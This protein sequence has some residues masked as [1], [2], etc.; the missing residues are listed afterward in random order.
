MHV[1]T[2]PTPE[3]GDRSYIVDDGTWGVVVDP[4]RDIDRWQQVI[5]ERGL[6]I[7]MVCE[8]HRHNDY[9]TGGAAL[10]RELGA[11]YVVP[12]GEV[13]DRCDEGVS[14]GQRI[15]FGNLSL[16]VVETPGHTLGHVSYVVSHAGDV[17]SHAGDVVSHAGDVV[18]HARD[19]VSHARDVV[20]HAGDVVSHARDVVSDPQAASVAFTGGSLLYGN[21]GR[22]D[23]VDPERTRE[24]T[25]AQLRSVRR[26]A[27]GLDEETLLYP[28][29]GFGSFCAAGAPSTVEVS[30]VG[31]ERLANLAL[32]SISEPEFV[33]ELISGLSD[34]PSYY[35]HV[36]EINR[37]GP[38]AFAP[39]PVETL[40]PEQLAA[41][42]GAG[43]WVVDLRDSHSF[44]ASHLAGTVNFPLDR[45]LATWLGWLAPWGAP[46]TLLAP[47]VDVAMVA[48]RALSRIGVDPAGVVVTGEVAALAAAVGAEVQSYPVRTWDDVVHAGPPNRKSDG[49]HVA[50]GILDVRT[51]DERREGGVA[52]SLHIPLHQLP[53]RIDSLPAE[54]LW[55]HCQSGYRAA[56]AAS[57]IERVGGDV[58]LIQGSYDR[59]RL[60]M[61]QEN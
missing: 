11:A 55:V 36:G 56:I 45:Q 1:T 24:L 47:D 30:T 44:A 59:T 40:A 12:V 3:L 31:R 5:D 46:I 22:T 52:G 26:L 57:L 27:G 25:R 7:A 50:V 6:R 38:S 23:L 53:E 48:L 28:T 41:R 37:R 42:L 19:V 39:R 33:A 20:S 16:R 34:Y 8:T 49:S 17:V 58:V 54:P 10:A 61:T 2:V 32:S 14:D 21:V 43:Q 60:P 9:V 4:Q 35:R 13:F 51:D 18:S 29:H 15:S